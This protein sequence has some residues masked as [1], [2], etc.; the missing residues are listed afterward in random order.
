MTAPSQIDTTSLLT[1]LGVI[2]AVWALISPTSRLRLRFC[3]A[4]WDWCIGGVVFLTHSLFSVC[5]CL[6]KLGPNYSPRPWKWGLNSSSYGFTYFS[7][8]PPYTTFGA[9]GLLNWPGKELHLLAS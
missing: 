2:A 7:L 9:Q 4:W 6:E 8:A 5:S 1:I 3:M